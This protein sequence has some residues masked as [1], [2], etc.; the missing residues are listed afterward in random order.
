MRLPGVGLRKH[1]LGWAHEL[2]RFQLVWSLLDLCC[3]SVTQL[4]S[5]TLSLI[6]APLGVIECLNSTFFV[7]FWALRKPVTLGIGGLLTLRLTTDSF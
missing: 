6:D 4:V 7:S 5:E 2:E 3:R 1:G